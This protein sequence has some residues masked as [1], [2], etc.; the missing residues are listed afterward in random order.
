MAGWSRGLGTGALGSLH[1]VEVGGCQVE[2][3]GPSPQLSSGLGES[4]DGSS[5][6]FLKMRTKSESFF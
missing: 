1:R 5:K 2:K 4:V 6:S 3:A